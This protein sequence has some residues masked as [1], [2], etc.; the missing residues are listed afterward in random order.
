M[1]K[2]QK[3]TS[4]PPQK[5]TDKPSLRQDQAQAIMQQLVSEGVFAPN[6]AAEVTFSDLAF[7]CI[8]DTEQKPAD[9]KG[10]K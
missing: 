7:I 6:E 2:N 5:Y 9:K 8:P 10:V 4:A 3:R 1:D